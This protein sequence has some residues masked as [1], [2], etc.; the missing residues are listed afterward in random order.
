MGFC[1][2][3]YRGFAVLLLG[4]WSVSLPAAD[5][6]V[7]RLAYLLGAPTVTDVPMQL[8]KEAYRH[9]GLK[10]EM[11][12]LPTARSLMSANDGTYD[13]EVARFRYIE[14]SVPNLKRVPVS[15]GHI[16]YAPYILGTN[17]VDLS[18]WA[19]IKS[20]G[21]RVAG[22]QG[23]RIVETALGNAVTTRNNSYEALLKMLLMRRV[24]VV[25]APVGE[26]EALYASMPL[27]LNAQLN[28]LKRLPPVASEP[29]YHYLHER[30]SD[31]IEPLT[32]ELKR[33][34]AN[35]TIGKYWKA[36]NR[37]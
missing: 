11:V 1:R 29:L 20:S 14:A 27:E 28:E 12:G 37:Q 19:A 25:I 10:V 15:L 26:L 4:V 8:V 6:D 16:E 3:W 32:K 17:R 9:L 13:G 18:S 2:A 22:R 31:L 34:E 33:M 24:D 7:Y 21:L 5:V 36:Q 23:A 30:N 35:G